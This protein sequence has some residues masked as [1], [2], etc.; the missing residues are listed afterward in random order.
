MG[1]QN[2]SDSTCSDCIASELYD[3]SFSSKV[4]LSNY[5][6][7]PFAQ[8]F[9]DTVDQTFATHWYTTFSELGIFL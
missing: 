6:S 4:T 3:Y 7:S 1:G 2:C 9:P 8:A 5:F